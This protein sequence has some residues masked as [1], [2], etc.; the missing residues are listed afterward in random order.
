MW[1]KWSC[2]FEAPF[3]A[4][5]LRQLWTKHNINGDQCIAAIA[6]AAHLFFAAGAPAYND[7]LS[8]VL[9]EMLASHHNLFDE[10]GIS[11]EVLKETVQTR[12]SS[13]WE[14]IP[15]DLLK[16]CPNFQQYT[17][18]ICGWLGFKPVPDWS[19]YYTQ[20]LMERFQ[21]IVNMT[22]VPYN[23][24]YPSR[25]H[26]SGALGG[27]ERTVQK[28]TNPQPLD[29]LRIYSSALTRAFRATVA[30]AR[31]SLRER[32]SGDQLSAVE[33]KLIRAYAEELHNELTRS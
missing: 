30:D 15:N 9:D 8:Y 14:L 21:K 4:P 2:L 11:A 29:L 24:N 1:R 33:D 31:K 22:W 19:G 20:A 25:G 27:A 6:L 13:E 10:M 17:E 23:S 12:A 3:A 32:Y 28:L 16:E 18:D 26:V 7:A 5:F